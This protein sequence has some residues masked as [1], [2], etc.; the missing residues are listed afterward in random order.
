MNRV[1]ATWS[2]KDPHTRIY[3]YILYVH[4]LGVYVRMHVCP[5]LLRRLLWCFGRPCRAK[6]PEVRS[7]GPESEV[8]KTPVSKT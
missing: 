1:A 4:Y 8:T 3:V 7:P 2:P 5:W 6:L